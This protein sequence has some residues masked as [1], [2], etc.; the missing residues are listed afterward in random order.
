[1][2]EVENDWL[3]CQYGSQKVPKLYLLFIFRNARGLTKTKQN[4]KENSGKVNKVWK[5]IVNIGIKH[6]RKPVITMEVFDGDDTTI[7]GDVNKVL[8]KW[9]D[10]IASL[11]KDKHGFDDRI[12]AG[13]K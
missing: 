8:S 12:L 10:D 1:M 5:S 4:R 9:M 6:D 7:T 13:V 2:C 11:F 3:L